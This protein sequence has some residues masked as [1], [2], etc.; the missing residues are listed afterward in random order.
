MSGYNDDITRRK[1]LYIG[2]VLAVPLFVVLQY[3]SYLRN[4]GGTT[5]LDCSWRLVDEV[6]VLLDPV[7]MPVSRGREQRVVGVGSGQGTENSL[8]A[9]VGDQL[10]VRWRERPA[11]ATTLV[12]TRVDNEGSKSFAN[13]GDR[14]KF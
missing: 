1:V 4:E 3:L 6:R 11:H 7:G 9:F 8:D 5:C 12:R 14:S 13:T 10:M 2:V